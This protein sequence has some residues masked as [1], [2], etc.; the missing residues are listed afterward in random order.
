M[1]A[2][3]PPDYF[4]SL[5]RGAVE[6]PPLLVSTLMA[7]CRNPS[8]KNQGLGPASQKSPSLPPV[9]LGLTTV[10]KF[11]IYGVLKLDKVSQ[12]ACLIAEA[13]NSRLGRQATGISSRY[14]LVRPTLFDLCSSYSRGLGCLRVSWFVRHLI[15][16]SIVNI[17]SRLFAA[18][19]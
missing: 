14:R 7:G 17:E 1:N 19:G 6:S 12:S 2:I 3:V 4:R 8:R 11:S 16:L 13:S 5:A 9:A 10:P 15:H 18:A